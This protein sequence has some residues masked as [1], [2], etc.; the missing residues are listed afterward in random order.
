VLAEVIVDEVEVLIGHE[1]T[2]LAQQL[3]DLDKV[4]TSARYETGDIDKVGG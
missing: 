4:V 3:A 2:V 1:D